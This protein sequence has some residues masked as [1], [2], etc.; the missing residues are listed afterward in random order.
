MDTVPLLPGILLQGQNKE[1]QTDH[2]IFLPHQ[3]C[4]RQKETLTFMCSPFL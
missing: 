4:T 1:T 2:V 3:K